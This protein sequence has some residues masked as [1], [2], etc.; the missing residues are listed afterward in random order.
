MKRLIAILTLVMIGLPTFAKG[1]WKGKVVDEN[2]E[3]VP[4]ANVAILSKA[5]STVVCG[6]VTADDGTFN[7]VTSET[8]GIMM[9]A[10]MGYRTVYLAPIDGAVITL[11]ADTAMLEG[12]DLLGTAHFDAYSDF[13]SHTIMQ[14]NRMDTQRI[15]LSIRYNFNTAQSKYRGSGAG[16]DSR[17]RM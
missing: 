12:A 7:I 14:T 2:G 3:V 11:E 1:D 9:V 5:D 10:M 13:G 16:A 4:Y 15:K 6:T 17:E 8:D